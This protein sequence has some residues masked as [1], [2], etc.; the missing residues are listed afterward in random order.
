MSKS[1]EDCNIKVDRD[2]ESCVIK[3]ESVGQASL[4][5]EVV[6]QIN[7]LKQEVDEILKGQKS[8]TQSPSGVLDA[9]NKLQLRITSLTDSIQNI[10]KHASDETKYHEELNC[11]NDGIKKRLDE[12]STWFKDQQKASQLSQANLDGIRQLQTKID[13]L[14]KQNQ[15]VATRIQD[16]SKARDDSFKRRLDKIDDVKNDIKQ[17]IQT[18]QKTAQQNPRENI[19]IDEMK[20]LQAKFDGLEK[21]NQNA[22][23]RNNDDSKNHDSLVK[24]LN[25]DLI[26]KLNDI[27]KQVSQPP[28]G[29]QEQLAVL[30]E[31]Q[32]RIVPL[33]KAVDKQQEQ[34][35]T[36]AIKALE[37]K[38]E[39][40]YAAID[41][42]A[43]NQQSQK[44]N[45]SQLLNELAKRVVKLDD[46]E[47]HLKQLPSS[48]VAIKRLGDHI[49]QIQAYLEK[50]SLV[51]DELKQRISDLVK[52]LKAVKLQD[53]SKEIAA[54]IQPILRVLDKQ[55]QND[56]IKNLAQK[57]NDIDKQLQTRQSSTTDAI[58]ALKNEIGQIHQG[59]DNQAQSQ[60]QGKEKESACLSDMTRKVDQLHENV[61]KFTQQQPDV[62]KDITNRLIPVIE[63]Q[64]QDKEK[65]QN[66]IRQ[67]NDDLMKEVSNLKSVL[68]P[69]VQAQ[70]QSPDV[71]RSIMD[72]ITQL[73]Q[74]FEKS[75]QND[76]DVKK[77]LADLKNAMYDVTQ[78]QKQSSSIMKPVLDSLD[79]ILRAIEKPNVNDEIMKKLDTLKPP[80]CPPPIDIGR[81]I[82]S[83]I[84][85]MMKKITD[86]VERQKQA[87]QQQSDQVR[88]EIEA[89][90][91]SLHHQ[92]TRDSGEWNQRSDQISKKLDDLVQSQRQLP[93][94]LK[95]ISDSIRVFQ[96]ALVTPAKTDDNLKKKLDDLNEEIQEPLQVSLGILDA[97]KALETK[98]IQQNPQK[99][100][101]DLKHEIKDELANL[102]K[103]GPS[104]D[105]IKQLQNRLG[106]LQDTLDKQKLNA[107]GTQI[108]QYDDVRTNI[109]KLTKKLDDCILSKQNNQ[110]L[111]QS[112]ATLKDL[113]DRLKSLEDNIRK[114]SDI[115]KLQ[116][117]R[118]FTDDSTGLQLQKSLEQINYLTSQ[119]KQFNNDTTHHHKEQS[120]TRSVLH[121]QSPLSPT[122]FNNGQIANLL[123]NL[124]S[125][126]SIIKNSE[127]VSCNNIQKYLQRIGGMDDIRQDQDLSSLVANVLEMCRNKNSILP[128]RK[129]RSE[130]P[131]QSITENNLSLSSPLQQPLASQPKSNTP[132][133]SPISS[134]LNRL[135]QTT[136]S[137]AS[138]GGITYS[139]GLALPPCYMTKSRYILF[140]SDR[141]INDHWKN[142][143]QK[144]HPVLQTILQTPLEI[145]DGNAIP[146]LVERRSDLKHYYSNYRN[147]ISSPSDYDQISYM[148][149]SIAFPNMTMIGSREAVIRP[150][151]PCLLNR[152][153][154]SGPYRFPAGN[155]QI[156]E[157]FKV[158]RDIALWMVETDENKPYNPSEFIPNIRRLNEK[159]ANILHPQYNEIRQQKRSDETRWNERYA[160]TKDNR[161]VLFVNDLRSYFM[162]YDTK[163][164][165]QVH[166]GVP[167]N[168]VCRTG[169]AGR[170]DLPFW[171]PNHCSCIVLLRDL[172]DPE[173]VLMRHKQHSD[174]LVLPKVYV[175]LTPQPNLDAKPSVL[176]KGFYGHEIRY[177]NMSKVI[178]DPVSGQML[179][180]NLLDYWWNET[181]K[182]N[183]DTNKSNHL[184]KVLTDKDIKEE[185]KELFSQ[186][187]C[188]KSVVSIIHQFDNGYIDHPLNTDHA[189]VESSVWKVQFKE[190]RV[191]AMNEDKYMVAADIHDQKHSFIWMKLM[192]A[193]LIVPDFDRGIL[194]DVLGTGMPL[195]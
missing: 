13:A 107:N 23:Q 47:K 105:T 82:T 135:D 74:T 143:K 98:I 92:A 12:L 124:L 168:P 96:Q 134:S 56:D 100:A 3:I 174:A 15:A 75:H 159:Y 128:L 115:I 161:T 42:E 190:W 118:S 39:Q 108:E 17:L 70:K 76:D 142:F 186:K 6:K 181:I 35:P 67:R 106:L 163:R 37:D 29:L 169:I 63:S 130:S 94:N 192:D 129:E 158:N 55:H 77:Q 40:F 32:A 112:T 109:D 16:D 38:I 144:N 195:L 136:A 48:E 95:E 170:G 160:F 139:R 151:D 73:K 185:F 88:K 89:K 122:D 187:G 179:P 103:N 28:A 165:Y 53:V 49:A 189:W 164:K 51:S 116:Q 61:Q 153:S 133:K 41:K 64:R 150:W 52:E 93:E 147:A 54:Q 59:I 9:I 175:L 81:E 36:G 140:I 176:F 127:D 44:S 132:N 21:Q 62:A 27:E 97:I 34:N 46:I 66:E 138:A 91:A 18:Q 193:I 10:A 184:K 173:V 99:V 157:R 131:K 182:L 102:S 86:I 72:Q 65:T 8:A 4:L 50:T 69:M 2:G 14:E 43:R 154:S 80:L 183:E 191:P 171:G 57:L 83:C 71:M 114:L 145:E 167:I 152:A 188:N 148:M 33:Q 104:N 5:H 125:L 26:T 126:E 155:D 120:Q 166:D 137:K 87:A 113:N 31:V 110:Q 19:I 119:M 121:A 11:L 149:D 30:K 58:K 156:V 172:S 101:D 20:Q 68:I 25:V 123:I 111:D 78:V 141:T 177:D 178:Q 22:L 90:M 85:P 162:D 24:K 60:Q 146:R 45:D 180:P 194:L 117:Q 7:D 1:K 79:H 84:A